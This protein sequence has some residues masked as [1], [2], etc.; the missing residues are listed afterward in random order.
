M[1]EIEVFF[2]KSVK[3]RKRLD[4]QLMKSKD[5]ALTEELMKLVLQVYENT[6]SVS[7]TSTI[8]WEQY[9]KK[10]SYQKV[11]RVLI[12]FHKFENETSRRIGELSAEGFSAAQIGARMGMS[13]VSVIS[14]LPYQEKKIYQKADVKEE[15]ERAGSGAGQLE[16]LSVNGIHMDNLWDIITSRQGETFYTKKKLPFSYTVKGGEMFTDRRERSITRS[17]FETAFRRLLES[18]A[19]VTGPKSLNVYGAP[20]V[21]AVLAGIGVTNG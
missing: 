9:Q 7:R 15:A 3:I 14:Y 4:I 12:T 19:T 10:I 5:E 11:R 21:W 6:Q 13:Y 16:K 17:T 2:C 8:L 18:P 1:I 20:Y